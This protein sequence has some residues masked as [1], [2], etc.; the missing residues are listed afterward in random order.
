MRVPVGELTRI[1][2]RLRRGNIRVMDSTREGVVKSG[3]LKLD[4]VTAA[5]HVQAPGGSI[6]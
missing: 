6:R 1:G 3:R 2:I 4:L 5:G